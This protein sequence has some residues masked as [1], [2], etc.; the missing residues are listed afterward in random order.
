RIRDASQVVAAITALPEVA[1]AVPLVFGDAEVTSANRARPLKVSF[2][3]AAASTRRPWTIVEGR[4]LASGAGL[5]GQVLLNR[6]LADLLGRRPGE[7]VTLRASCSAG[8][9][10]VPAVVLEV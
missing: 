8:P 2:F 1:E 7:A 3:A 5:T 10:A 6:R 9:S 4:D